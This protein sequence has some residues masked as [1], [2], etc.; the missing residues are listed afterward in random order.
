[1][2]T[3][4]EVSEA[5][6]ALAIARAVA[7]DATA[8]L[9]GAA[10]HVGQIRS[11]TNPRDL[12]TE[13]DT[14]VEELIRAR[15][16]A[17]TPGIPIL[18]EE[19]GLSGDPS[20]IQGS[21]PGSIQG[22]DPGSIQGSDPGSIQG[23]DPGSIQGSDPELIWLV[24]PIDGTVNFSHGLPLWSV[25]ISLERR[26]R[27]VAGVVRA[28]ALGWEYHATRGGG[29]YLGDDRLQVS[30]IASLDQALLVT[31]FPYDRATSPYNNFAHWEHFQRVA[32]ACRRLGSA[33]LD[34]C[35]VARGSLDGYWER[36][37]KPWDVSAG[38]LIVSEA[39][40]VIT[41]T[42]GGTFHSAKGEAVASNGA[43]HGEILRELAAVDAR[44]STQRAT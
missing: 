20:S 22:S 40:G 4:S 24:D 6:D 42:Q 41:D 8:L 30:S 38:G 23:S 16:Q 10:G 19:G 21:D 31:G 7:A 2:T 35:F 26:G 14:R 39:G 28:P 18:G 25:C 17:L 37:L 33:S 15:L 36:R 1:V 9:A 44:I 12:V 5:A 32:G 29:A 3:P 27:A 13:W 34:L 11:K 43:I